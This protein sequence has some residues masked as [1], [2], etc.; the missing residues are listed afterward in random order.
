MNSKEVFN[1]IKGIFYSSLSC[2]RKTF[3]SAYNAIFYAID[4]IFTNRTPRYLIERMRDIM[5][6]R[7]DRVYDRVD[8]SLDTTRHRLDQIPTE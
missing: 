6:N 4:C 7:L 3:S 1:A 8:R 2:I 5:K